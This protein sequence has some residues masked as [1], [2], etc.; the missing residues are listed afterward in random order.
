M[1]HIL[2]IIAKQAQDLREKFD[3]A[4]RVTEVEEAKKVYDHMK[5]QIKSISKHHGYRQLKDWFKRLMDA[6]ERLITTKGL[7]DEKLKEAVAEYRVTKNFL[8][9]LNNIEKSK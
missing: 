9:F 7:T 6:N 2:D 3:L 5:V 4:Q 1:T 8:S